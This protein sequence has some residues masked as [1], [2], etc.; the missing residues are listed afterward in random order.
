MAPHVN[1]ENMVKAMGAVLQP[2]MPALTA[3]AMDT[4]SQDMAAATKDP[5]LIA[6]TNLA[7]GWV[8]EHGLEEGAAF[9]GRLHNALRDDDFSAMADLSAKQ[10][11][12]LT[13]AH[14]TA[15]A[16]SRIQT[17]RTLHRLGSI[18]GDFSRY[19]GRAFL[20]ALV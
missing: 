2:Q 19:A 8:K 15:E 18:L 3:A 17:Q 13:D 12:E 16:N 6:A 20:V 1:L 7:T 11:T 4:I 14:Q 9:T 10:L 5:L